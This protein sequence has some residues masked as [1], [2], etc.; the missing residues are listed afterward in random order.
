MTRT[1]RTLKS[2][3]VIS[4]SDTLEMFFYSNPNLE[5]GESVILRSCDGD[6][7]TAE[8]SDIEEDRG[9]VYFELS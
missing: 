2:S 5:V 4:S 9:A 6:L 7:F 1:L 8:V 3:K